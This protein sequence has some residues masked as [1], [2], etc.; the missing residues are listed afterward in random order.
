MR[1]VTD[2][3]QIRPALH[4]DP[5]SLVRVLQ[6]SDP[7][8]ARRGLCFV[9]GCQPTGAGCGTGLETGLGASSHRRP[10]CL[11]ISGDLCQER[12]LAGYRQLGELAGTL[13]DSPG[14][15]ARKP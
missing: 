8:L 14:P 4:Q 7:H 9:S 15:A 10:T 3:W 11:L 6:L 1:M 13:R 12:D 2:R 5:L